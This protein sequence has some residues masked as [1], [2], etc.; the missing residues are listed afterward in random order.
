MQQ[1]G[2]HPGKA[3]DAEQSHVTVDFLGEK[4]DRTTNAGLPAA[5]ARHNASR[6]ASIWRAFGSTKA[7]K[8]SSLTCLNQFLATKVNII[9]PNEA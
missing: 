5:A 4:G 7:P 1:A 6:G 2:S 9:K 3:G 8:R